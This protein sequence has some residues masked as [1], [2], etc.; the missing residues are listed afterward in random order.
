MALGNFRI[1]QCKYYG[2]NL[3]LYFLPSSGVT[4][5][6]QASP[7]EIRKKNIGRA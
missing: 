6:A 5:E 4:L 2:F 7:S 1:N 3:I